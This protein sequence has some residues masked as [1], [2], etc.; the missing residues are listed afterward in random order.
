MDWHWALR[1]R[2]GTIH[3]PR[4]SQLMMSLS[5]SLQLFAKVKAA[6]SSSTALWRA[7]VGLFYRLSAWEDMSLF[8]AAWMESQQPLRLRRKCPNSAT[9]YLAVQKILF[10]GMSWELM[11]RTYDG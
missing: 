4:R 6:S 5:R 8:F 9:A 1:I 11:S 2:E 7:V 3:S 10:L